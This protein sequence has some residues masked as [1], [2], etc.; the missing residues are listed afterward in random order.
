M[1]RLLACYG[2]NTLI[3]LHDFP[4]D[5]NPNEDAELVEA[6][7]RHQHNNLP[8]DRRRGL[9]FRCDQ[10]TYDVLDVEQSIK[11]AELKVGGKLFNETRD[12]FKDDAMRCYIRHGSPGVDTGCVDFR[13]EAKAMGNYKKVHPDERRYICS[14]CPLGTMWATDDQ[15][16]AGARRGSR[17]IAV[18]VRLTTP[19][20]RARWGNI[21]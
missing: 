17:G 13:T 18:P 3:K 9:I 5:R 1:P 6:C 16:R 21:R 10:A 14:Y 19:I 8:E 12:E 2:C 15:L 11:D 20:G 4:D 7:N